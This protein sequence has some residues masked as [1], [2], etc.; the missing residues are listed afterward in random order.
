M[1][2]EPADLS[3]LFVFEGDWNFTVCTNC[4]ICTDQLTIWQGMARK[5]T[6]QTANS[7]SV[8]VIFPTC[9]P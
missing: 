8:W 1:C 4:R 7:F 6:V 2:R 3:R 9:G 5:F